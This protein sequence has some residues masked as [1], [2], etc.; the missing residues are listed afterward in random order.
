M[1]RVDKSGW[2][3]GELR[4]KQGLF[5]ANYCKLL[6]GDDEDSSYDE[7][8]DSLSWSSDEEA[9]RKKDSAA[10]MMQVCRVCELAQDASLLCRQCGCSLADVPMQ[11]KEEFLR[12]NL[13]NSI[14]QV[15]SIKL[16][17]VASPDET[18][19]AKT[20][21]KLSSLEAALSKTRKAANGDDE[22]DDD[23]E[24]WK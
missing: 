5:P 2:W 12:G 8:D 20:A 17:K 14:R 23:E 1:I 19:A 15:A 22:R 13:L 18:A 11:P 4:G 10:A 16:R 3:L 21:P 7:E 6:Y 24:D 9:D